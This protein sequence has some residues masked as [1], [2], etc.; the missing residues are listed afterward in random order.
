MFPQSVSWRVRHPI[1]G[2]HLWILLWV[3]SNSNA[4]VLWLGEV[5]DYL[6]IHHS[7]GTGVF[8]GLLGPTAVDIMKAFTKF[9]LHAKHVWP[10]HFKDLH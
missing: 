2:A 8:K 9:D 4:N 1:L 7:L 3:F 5:T 10:L 6:H